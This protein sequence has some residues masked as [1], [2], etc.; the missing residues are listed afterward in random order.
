MCSNQGGIAS[1][2]EGKMSL[3]LRERAEQAFEKVL[4]YAHVY[5][6]SHWEHICSSTSPFSAADKCKVA[7]QLPWWLSRVLL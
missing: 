5:T 2:L 6:Q 1:Q 3:K 4:A 7:G